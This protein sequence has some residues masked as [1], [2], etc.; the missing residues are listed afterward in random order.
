MRSGQFSFP[1][2]KLLNEIITKAFYPRILDTTIILSY[3]N[4]PLSCSRD[5]MSVNQRRRIFYCVLF[6][7][8]GSIKHLIP[9][10]MCL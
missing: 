3:I 1:P 6:S 8:V 5:K 2:Q 9:R 7:A 4:L 10:H